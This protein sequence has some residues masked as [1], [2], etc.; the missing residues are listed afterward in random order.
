MEQVPYLGEQVK[1]QKKSRVVDT[2]R[3]HEKAAEGEQLDAIDVDV[4]GQ[5]GTVCS[6]S[7]F[8][9]ERGEQM[10]PIRLAGADGRPNPQGPIVSVPVD[11]LETPNSGGI[12]SRFSRAFAAGWERIFGGRD[13]TEKEEA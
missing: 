2:E 4:T 8:N 1:I 9:P 3:A 6:S 10:V 12:R 5:K 7:Y 13:K 11:R